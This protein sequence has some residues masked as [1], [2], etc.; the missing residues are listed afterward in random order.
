M[1]SYVWGL[2][3]IDD[4]VL[5]EK[6][7]ER[8][9]SLADP[10]WNVVALVN[11]S[12]AVVE[13]MKYD[14]FGKITWLDASFGVKAN[15]DYNWNRTFTGQV[16]DAETML[17]C[18]RNRYYNVD[19]GRFI[20][21]DPLKYDASDTNLY[22]YVLNNATTEV[23]MYGLMKPDH[24]MPW[25]PDNPHNPN[26]FNNGTP[27]NTPTPVPQKPLINSSCEICQNLRKSPGCSS[28]SSKICEAAIDNIIDAYATTPVPWGTNTCERWV[29]SF[30]KKLRIDTIINP[31]VK[32]AGVVHWDYKAYYG[33]T[34]GHA[35]YKI[36]F[37][38]GVALY[39]DNGGFG[40]V[41]DE[42][43]IPSAAVLTK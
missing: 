25:Q 39:F 18:Y 17:M 13:R 19:F 41:Y 29:L 12:G 5:R 2:R 21:A 40:R 33:S 14:A 35:A 27:P 10:N 34:T 36:K 26:G 31:C 9:Y 8:L 1:T 20:S 37:C 30:D 11:V 24:L 3:Y 16:L 6:Y 32:E 38:N 23:D 28:C 15:S 4:L 22:R 42:S 43:K 7:E